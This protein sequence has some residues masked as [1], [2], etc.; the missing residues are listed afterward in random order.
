[1][2]CEPA[3]FQLSDLPL[4]VGMGEWAH[5]L[6]DQ[7]CQ[8]QPNSITLEDSHC[9]D[10]DNVVELPP[11]A[12]DP[13]P[14][15][16]WQAVN[17]AGIENSQIVADLAHRSDGVG[18]LYRGR[19][20]WMSSAPEMGKS[21]IAL[22]I[23]CQVLEAGGRVLYFDF[24]DEATSF[25]ERMVALGV[26]RDLINDRDR[27]RYVR[28]DEPSGL[29]MSQ[30]D[31]VAAQAFAD[32]VAWSP[33]FVVIDGT[34]EAMVLEGA[35]PL[36]NSD[37]AAW[38][39]QKVR[40]FSSGGAGVLVLDH[41]AKATEPGSRYAIGAQHKLA[42]LDGLAIKAIA[43]KSFG[44]HP[45]GNCD[46]IEGLIRL[47]L[48]KDRAGAVRGALDAKTLADVRVLAYPD[49]RV[50]LSFDPPDAVQDV[51]LRCRIV[52]FLKGHPKSGKSAVL[53]GAKGNKQQLETELQTMIKA[54]LV[55]VTVV[56]KTHQHTLTA[57]G[58]GLV[59]DCGQQ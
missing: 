38:I 5:G 36:D 44:R 55:A 16:S 50:S 34:T 17:L 37:T 21:W 8:G 56:G 57:S 18:M 32:L 12:V 46:P 14:A 31:S 25:L 48:L 11:S 6:L 29:A 4:V 33:S 28:P 3:S 35:S 59:D 41:V 22:G 26:D 19:I 20:S 58:L 9:Q 51:N 27:V 2:A 54:E 39:R 1:M 13:T 30:P 42:A 52:N 47:E 53:S 23:A 7:I 24:E 43:L 45:G 40:P 10:Y 15:T 49:R